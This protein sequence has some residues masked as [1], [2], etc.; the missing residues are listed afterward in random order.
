MSQ[1]TETIRSSLRPRDVFYL[2]CLVL[3]PA[4]TVGAFVD[5]IDIT[6]FAKGFG[7]SAMAFSILIFGWTMFMHGCQHDE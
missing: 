4:A 3:I 6:I 5:A 7:W 1:T 2:V